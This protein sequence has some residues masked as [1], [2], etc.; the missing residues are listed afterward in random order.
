LKLAAIFSRG[1]FL[2][3]WFQS[4]EKLKHFY[5]AGFGWVCI[6]CEREFQREKPPEKKHSRMFREGE[7]ESKSPRLANHA[8]AKWLDILRT[9]LICPNCG[10]TEK[11]A[12]L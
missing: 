9:V 4:V 10:I 12:D 7:A 11:I 2:Y 5:N 6:E 3:S 8:L 1:F